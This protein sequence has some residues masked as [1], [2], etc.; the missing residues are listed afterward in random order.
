MFDT[1]TC[2]VSI[3]VFA[4]FWVL[5][6]AKTTALYVA[7]WR[8]ILELVPQMSRDGISIMG[9]FEAAPQ[10]AIR[11][12]LPNPL[13]R[14]CWFHFIQALLRMWKSLGLLDAPKQVLWMIM[15]LALFSANMFREALN[16]IQEHADIVANDFPRILEY[17]AYVRRQWLPR[18]Y[19]VSAYQCPIRTNNELEAFNRQLSERFIGTRR[20]AYTFHGKFSGSTLYFSE[21]YNIIV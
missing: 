16:I 9:D 15:S 3:H 12:V 11:E 8:K 17:M 5:V 7:I 19:I 18:A 13:L 14:G 1:R 2:L 10:S 20:N 21:I 6:E 4:G